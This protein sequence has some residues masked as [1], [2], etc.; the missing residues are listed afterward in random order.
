MKILVEKNGYF[1]VKPKGFLIELKGDKAAPLYSA[2]VQ[3]RYR[4]AIPVDVYKLHLVEDDDLLKV[5]KN[6]DFMVTPKD[7]SITEDLTKG[8]IRVGHHIV[9]SI[10]GVQAYESTVNDIFQFYAEV[11]DPDTDAATQA[12]MIQELEEALN[13]VETV[14][15]AKEGIKESKEPIQEPKIDGII[16]E[17]NQLLGSLTSKIDT[18]EYC[19]SLSSKIHGDVVKV[20]IKDW[21]K[22]LGILDVDNTDHVGIVERTAELTMK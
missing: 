8:C 3:T 6:G 13:C 4:G 20:D 16:G 5:H 9:V 12:K 10:A 17:I 18:E 19:L 7:A 2:L 22:I 21:F 14:E 1:M 11:K 15:K